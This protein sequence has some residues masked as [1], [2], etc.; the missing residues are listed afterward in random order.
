MTDDEAPRGDSA[1]GDTDKSNDNEN[2][3]NQKL[4]ARVEALETELQKALVAR[5]T[6]IREVLP[7][8]G[9]GGVVSEQGS[10][11]KGSRL[12]TISVILLLLGGI[13]LLT[14]Q[15]ATT[16]STMR[17]PNAAQK[18]GKASQRRAGKKVGYRAAKRRP[19]VAAPGG[20]VRRDQ[21]KKMPVGELSHLGRVSLHANGRYVVAAGSG[22]KILLYDL[23]TARIL[24]VNVAH[25]GET[26]DAVFVSPLLIAS[27]GSDGAVHL[28][29]ARDGV[30]M[31]TLRSAGPPVMRLASAAGL[32]AVA[33]LQPHI[34]LYRVSD[35]VAASGQDAGAAKRPKALR[36]KGDAREALTVALSADG[37]LLATGGHEGVIYLV[38]LVAGKPRGKPRKI[39]A[40]RQWIAAL[41]FSRDK[42]LLASSGFEKRVRVWDVASGKRMHSFRGHVRRC[43]DLA[44]DSRG[45]RLATASLDQASGQIRQTAARGAQKARLPIAQRSRWPSKAARSALGQ[46][47]R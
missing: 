9:S 15:M 47:D 45:Q 8:S 21:I 46:V 33:A 5:D 38:E 32:L 11:K 35:K 36:I 39:K 37:K 29:R 26:R 4:R 7:L 13:G 31:Q 14:R 34:E 25:R 20:V 10:R 6:L 28:F 17:R 44:F 2:A 1:S 19:P 42:R 27:G 40:H 12:L 3:E 22:G 30:R 24:W 23:A 16:V 18:D 43:L 41:R